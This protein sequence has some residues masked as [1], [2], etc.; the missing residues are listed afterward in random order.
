M[1]VALGNMKHI[2]YKDKSIKS[3][4]SNKHSMRVFC[5]YEKSQ[6]QNIFLNNGCKIPLGERVKTGATYNT[7]L[8]SYY[9]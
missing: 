3:F 1:E 8:E 4:P 5:N 6:D 7:M 9:I 2:K